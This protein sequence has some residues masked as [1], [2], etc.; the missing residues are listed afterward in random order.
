MEVEFKSQ[1]IVRFGG[2]ML[3]F[4]RCQAERLCQPQKMLMRESDKEHRAAQGA[5]ES[6]CHRL[7]SRT[8]SKDD[9]EISLFSFFLRGGWSWKKQR[10][11]GGG[12]T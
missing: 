5:G 12:G 1:C 11:G 8:L 2:I 6:I 7:R 9:T 4:R 10:E 3:A